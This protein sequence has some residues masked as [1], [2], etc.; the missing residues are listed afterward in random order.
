MPRAV[1]DAARAAAPCAVGGWDRA[2]GSSRPRQRQADCI[3]AALALGTR[4]CSVVM[5]R[6]LEPDRWCLAGTVVSPSRGSQGTGALASNT[7]AIFFAAAA[8]RRSGD[9][10]S[11][12][13]KTLASRLK[14]LCQM[15]SGWARQSWQQVSKRH[16]YF[17]WH[18]AK[19]RQGRPLQLFFSPELDGL[20]PQLA[21]S[22]AAE[23]RW[24][25]RAAGEMMTGT[26]FS[27]SSG[28]HPRW[29][30]I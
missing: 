20:A 19:R 27:D 28:M 1:P 3:R 14:R 17:V 11:R 10:H 2:D 15:V 12:R 16:A 5:Q 30:K 7:H 25:N 9:V 21:T 29:A 24:W 13:L 18:L 22:A 26:L 8:A 23:V 4:S 6:W